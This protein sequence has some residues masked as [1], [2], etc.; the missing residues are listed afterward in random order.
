MPE[1]AFTMH[2]P[3]RR[4]E[5]D[6]FS[7]VHD[8]VFQQYMEEAAIQASTAGGLGVEWYD[9]HGTVWVIREM[10]IEFLH[11]A[12]IDDVLDI[13]TWV[14][15]VRRVRSHREYQV[16]RSRDHQLLVRASC[17]WVYINRATLW[18]IRIPADAIAALPA[19]GEYAVAA[20]PAVLALPADVQ[21]ETTCRRRA[22]RHEIDGMGH[23]NNA[24]YV[25][26][27]EQAVLDALDIW[28]PQRTG[29]P[30]WRRHHIEYISAILP[31]EEVEIT[32]RLVGLDGGRAAW[33]QVVRRAGSDQPAIT[34]ECVVLYLDAR[35]RARR[36]PQQLTLP[37]A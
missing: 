24:V 23:V 18:P 7:Q 28:L 14:S 34:D 17:D 32:S 33:R 9:H 15:D 20:V 31:G 22:Q 4:Y 6:R 10:T 36:W 29:W 3:V 35:R 11:P 13:R 12:G 16:F 1:T 19:N 30:A 21:R 26:W 27:F 2:L 37:A 5:V 8:H 25:T